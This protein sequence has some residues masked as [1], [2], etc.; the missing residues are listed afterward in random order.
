[1]FGE[2]L[3]E[4][5]KDHGHTQA[6][7][8]E[9]LH[10]SVFSV[11]AYEQG[12]TWPQLPTLLHIC[13]LYKVSS[14]YLLGLSDDYGPEYLGGHG[15]SSCLSEEEWSKIKEYEQFLVYQRK[16]KASKV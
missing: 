6:D 12:R 1:M 10:V 8:A 16:N 11:S 4:V 15:R 9:L 5:R 7:L 3:S 13:K 14:D 2:R